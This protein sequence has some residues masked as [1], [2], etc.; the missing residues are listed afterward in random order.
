MRYDS[1]LNSMKWPSDSQKGS[2]TPCFLPTLSVVLFCLLPNHPFSKLGFSGLIQ[3]IFVKLYFGVSK[4]P[5]FNYW[6]I[7]SLDISDLTP[8]RPHQTLCHFMAFWVRLASAKW[9]L[10]LGMV[11]SH[12]LEE[13]KLLYLIWKSIFR[14]FIWTQILKYLLVK[15]SCSGQI[16]PLNDFA[17]V[18][19]QKYDPIQ[20]QPNLC[21]SIHPSLDNWA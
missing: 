20:V 17:L 10:H 1:L 7:F 8:F 2:A 13:S 9:P 18:Q 21:L 11:L 16:I 6:S 19:S 15:I 14:A 5:K 12:F 4:W 3:Q